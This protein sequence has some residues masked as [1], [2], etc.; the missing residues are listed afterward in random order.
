[1]ST[2]KFLKV[3]EFESLVKQEFGDTTKGIFERGKIVKENFH[4]ERKRESFLEKK[5]KKTADR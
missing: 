2:R 1:M 3:R 4:R 5:E